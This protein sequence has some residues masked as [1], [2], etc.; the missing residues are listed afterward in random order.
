[1]ESESL[2]LLVMRHAKS[3]WST[4]D[5][6]F[7]R[8]LNPRG[9][10]NAVQMAQ[11][12]VDQD[13]APDRVLSSPARRA[14][15]TAMEVVSACGIDHAD[16]E[17]DEELYLAD[18]WTWLEQ[19]R[20]RAGQRVLI[21]GHNPGLDQLVDHLSGGTAPFSQS[22]KLMTTAAV[23]HFTHGPEWSSLGTTEGWCRLMSLTRP[24]EL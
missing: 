1:M 2:E 5:T 15:S 22:G 20:D 16:V 21:C 13:L 10:R 24:R 9:E 4:H 19:L 6:D 23:A 17:F 14:A 3:D 8:P 12:L 18:A 7:D 11:W